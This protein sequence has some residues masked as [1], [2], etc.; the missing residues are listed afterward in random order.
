MNITKSKTKRQ[1]IQH[2]AAKFRDC[3][4]DISRDDAYQMFQRSQFFRS[5]QTLNR[6][7]LFAYL[8]TPKD[9]WY[10]NL[11]FGDYRLELHYGCEIPFNR[12]A[13]MYAI[14]CLEKHIGFKATTQ[15]KELKKKK[16]SMV[17]D[18]GLATKIARKVNPLFVINDQKHQLEITNKERSFTY[19]ISKRRIKNRKLIT[20]ETSFTEILTRLSPL[21]E[22][23]EMWSCGLQGKHNMW[24][25]A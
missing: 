5:T 19:K 9:K 7:R 21:A 15:I 8:S 3:E 23:Q 17:K 11:T 4:S 13:C 1:I 2:F 16:L 22:F 24:I 14:E 12:E 20:D 10:I 6:P 18:E 25:K